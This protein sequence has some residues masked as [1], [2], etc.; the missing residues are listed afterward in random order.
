MA[1][2][3]IVIA[4]PDRPSTS[5]GHS[6]DEDSDW[7]SVVAS[8][9]LLMGQHRVTDTRIQ[10]ADTGRVEAADTDRPPLPRDVTII[11]LRRTEPKPREDDP[12]HPG[13]EY[14]RR[15]W[16]DGHWR[17]QACGPEHSQRKP[18]WIAPHIKGPEGLPLDEDKPRVH[19]WRR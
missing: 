5:R 7:L 3:E 2:R 17:Q 10:R 12:E 6:G 18:V 9:W 16:V 11:D 19:V 4:D 13:R 14:T 1:S 15:W 8:A